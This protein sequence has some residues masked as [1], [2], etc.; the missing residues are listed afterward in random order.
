MLEMAAWK[1]S[2]TLDNSTSDGAEG[3]GPNSAPRSARS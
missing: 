2:F 3:D 1:R